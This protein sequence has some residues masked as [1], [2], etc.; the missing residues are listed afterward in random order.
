MSTS[1][2]NWHRQEA[3][4]RSLREP[5]GLDF[6]RGLINAFIITATMA[7]IV[8]GFVLLINFARS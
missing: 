3:L 6:F 7:A 1:R 5:D 8:A 2:D 4:N